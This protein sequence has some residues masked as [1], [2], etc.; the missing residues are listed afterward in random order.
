[1]K[2]LIVED[3]PMVRTIN[4]GYLKK[5]DSDIKVFE[6]S[7]V[8]AA[9]QIVASNPIDLILLDVY[10]G[11]GL[12]PEL[13]TWAR[14]NEYDL[15]VVLITADNSYETVA[16][17]F[18][19]GAIDYLIKPFSFARFSEAIEK[20][21]LKRNALGIQTTVS[22]DDIDKMLTHGKEAVGEKG[23]NAMTYKLVKEGL[24][25]VGDPQTA[26]DLADKTQLARVTVRRYLE[27]MVEQGTVEEQLN[28]GKIGRP[29]KYYKWKETQS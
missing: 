29:N 12:G 21:K 4:K 20:V 9:K 24:M 1:M 16:T 14:L 25:S 18:R 7:H 5:I 22:Q 8:E 26:Q 13:L 19:L 3:D 27:Y 15:D 2:V 10:L 6:A 11:E 23:I 28:Y 17:S